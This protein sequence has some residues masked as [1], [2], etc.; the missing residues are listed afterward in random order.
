MYE[1]MCMPERGPGW[2]LGV[3]VGTR[4]SPTVTRSLCP[5]GKEVGILRRELLGTLSLIPLSMSVGKQLEWE[6]TETQQSQWV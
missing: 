5:G 2:N 3:C 1:F 6:S 4:L